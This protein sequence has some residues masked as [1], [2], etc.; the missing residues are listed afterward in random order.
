MGLRGQTQ[1]IRLG[2]KH[3][4]TGL[5]D[6]FFRDKVELCC[7]QWLTTASSAGF[8]G[9]N[10]YTQLT[11]FF[12][13]Y[14]EFCV[15][16]CA[17]EHMLCVCMYPQRLEEG[18]GSPWSCSHRWFVNC[19]AWVLETTPRTSRRVSRAKPPFYP[20]SFHVHAH[21]CVHACVCMYIYEYP[22]TWRS[23][24]TLWH[25][26]LF[27]FLWALGLNSTCQAMWQVSA[28]VSSC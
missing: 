26:S 2:G 20:L 3:S 11:L 25:C 13:I 15:C 17:C 24:T 14:F 7:P 21:V 28:T 22:C 16:L 4:L 9:K 10:N 19:L 23:G 12:K 5:Y 6:F 1:V 18:T 8:T 27:S